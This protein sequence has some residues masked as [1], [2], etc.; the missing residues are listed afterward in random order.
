MS[1][2]PFEKKRPTSG[3]VRAGD[4]SRTRQHDRI[5]YFK[6]EKAKRIAAGLAAQ[7]VAYAKPKSV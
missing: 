1:A 6:R 3:T 4:W 2:I 7:D 5:E